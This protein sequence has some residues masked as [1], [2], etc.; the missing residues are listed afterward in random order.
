MADFQKSLKRILAYEGGNANNPNDPGGRTSRGITQVVYDRWADKHKVSRGDVWL[1]SDATIAAI[2]KENYWNRIDGEK[3]PEGVALCIFDAAVNSGLAQTAKWVQRSLKIK[4]NGDF[5][6][7]TIDAV[8]SCVDQ[9]QLIKDICSRRLAML[10]SLPTWKHFGKGWL[11]RV[12]SVQAMSIYDAANVKP[13]PTPIDPPNPTPKAQIETKAAPIDQSAP[14]A[15]VAVGGV[16]TVIASAA[17]GLPDAIDKLSP[18]TVVWPH[19]AELCA[20]LTVISVVASLYVSFKHKQHEA[21]MNGSA[22]AT[23]EG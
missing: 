9:V 15:T 8:I 16:G 14:I 4:V 7:A 10:H 13:E 3:L 19:V 5:G 11:S 23:V 20:A 18:L 2:Y 22:Q 1:A 21:I 12:R 17:T 6:P